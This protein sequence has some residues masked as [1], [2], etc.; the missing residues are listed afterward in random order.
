MYLMPPLG[1]T[2]LKIRRYLWHRK[3]IE[4]LTIAW[5]CDRDPTFRQM[6]RETHDDSTYRASGAGIRWK[7]VDSN[8]RPRKYSNIR[9]LTSTHHHAL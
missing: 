1:V 4:S 3:T 8:I 5:L 9:I 2:A 7:K 6:D